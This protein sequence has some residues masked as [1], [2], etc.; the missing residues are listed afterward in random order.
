VDATEPICLSSGIAHLLVTR[1]PLH[2]W[3]AHRRLNPNYVREEKDAF[4]LGNVV[5]ELLLG[6]ES[7][8]VVGEFDEYRTNTAKA[9]RDEVRAAG[10][11]PLRPKDAPRVHEMHSRVI[12]QLATFDVDPPLLAKP[13]LAEETIV[14]RD[15]DADCKARLD[16]IHAGDVYAIDDV[17]TTS[18]SASPE[19]YARRLYEFGGDLQAAFYVRAVQERF[20]LLEAPAF[21]WIVCE[22]EPP[23]CV[24]VIQPGADVLALG[25]A[26]VELALARWTHAM[27][28]NEWPGYPAR[29]HT[30][31]L[32]PWEESRFLER[33][34]TIQ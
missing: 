3:T 20:A 16:W 4:D 13:G 11:I 29:V 19:A 30:A 12:E 31:E 1:S 27:T 18:R 32:P 17:K 6:Q 22:T 24:S 2:A 10:K 21:R 5:H 33:M 28:T 34:E 9:W 14:W 23:F 15:G 26:K 8:V 25:N 7:S